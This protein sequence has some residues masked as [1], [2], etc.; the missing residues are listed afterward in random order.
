MK[1]TITISFALILAFLG[2]S[3]EDYGDDFNKL[4]DR[5]DSLESQIAGFSDL[6]S[7]INALDS[8]IGSLS[9]VVDAIPDNEGFASSVTDI[10][11]QVEGLQE[12]LALLISGASD[13]SINAIDGLSGTLQE[14]VNAL[15]DQLAS[16]TLDLKTLLNANNVYPGDL[17]IRTEGAL[18][19]AL[20]YVKD[21]E[22]LIVNGALII[23]P[24]GIASGD[25]YLGQ[26][27]DAIEVNQLTSK[28]TAIL[29]RTLDV[30]YL[31]DD[32]EAIVAE[33]GNI[34]VGGEIQYIDGDLDFSN[35]RTLNGFIEIQD[36][37]GSVDLSALVRQTSLEWNAFVLEDGDYLDSDAEDVLDDDC[38][39][40]LDEVFSGALS[41][42]GALYFDDIYENINLSSL[43]SAYA[44]VFDDVEGS[45]G[46]DLSSLVT[47]D[48]DLATSDIDGG[49][50][51]PS[52]VEVGGNFVLDH[53]GNYDYPQLMSVGGIYGSS[54][55]YEYPSDMDGDL[56]MD[57][58]DTE[59]VNFPKLQ[60]VYGD[61]SVASIDEYYNDYAEID[62]YN[63]DNIFQMAT[64]VTIFYKFSNDLASFQVPG[65]CGSEERTSVYGFAAPNAT[66]VTINGEYDEWDGDYDI[67]EDLYVYAP[68][69]SVTLNV[70]NAA[71]D[72]AVNF[73][74]LT[75][76]GLYDVYQDL[77]L[78]GNDTEGSPSVTLDALTEAGDVYT[79]GLD[80]LKLTLFDTESN[81][82]YIYGAVNKLEVANLSHGALKLSYLEELTVTALDNYF[83][84][85]GILLDCEPVVGIIQNAMVMNTSLE[86]TLTTVSITGADC[87]ASIELGSND[88]I[89][90]YS[91]GFNAITSLTLGGTLDTAEVVGAEGL[92]TLTTSGTITNWIDVDNTPNTRI[93]NHTTGTC[94]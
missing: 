53:Y 30:S 73:T 1:K 61:I 2:G 7:G 91:T 92:E 64:S 88:D 28:I 55:D 42:S 94:D 80:E 39:D 3:C 27:F 86:T 85:S 50:V 18:D 81:E 9:T 82:A 89:D 75:T 45:L 83:D 33:I 76:S 47:V 19:A 63:Y 17:I 60:F 10:Q 41:Y 62:S 22:T 31:E 70:D 58:N 13:D 51:A 29:G 11:D 26:H 79:S 35:L 4:N 12:A 23:Q 37:Y 52:L 59:I 67:D 34:I 40:S 38:C 5:I 36:I 69:A 77:I 48:K 14:Q 49:L 32:D 74:S 16:I 71:Y 72:L 54:Y 15:N 46:I 21:R 65:E 24:D 78:V 66:S 6:S 87:G 44:L 93:T 43:V 8:K 57:D 90:G 68:K 84:F 56:I 20:E 25:D